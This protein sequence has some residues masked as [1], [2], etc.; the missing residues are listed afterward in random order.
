MFADPRLPL[1]SSVFPLRLP[2]LFPTPSPHF[3]PSQPG[4][5][6][7]AC[8][9]HSCQPLKRHRP[10][11][12][13]I[14]LDKG[15]RR[16]A[17]PLLKCEQSTPR[18]DVPP[19]QQS[20]R[21]PA[22]VHARGLQ[23]AFHPVS[24]LLPVH[25]CPFARFLRP[26]PSKFLF[27]LPVSLV[28]PLTSGWEPHRPTGA[29]PSSDAVKAPLPAGAEGSGAGGSCGRGRPPHS[30][31]HSVPHPGWLALK[32]LDLWPAIS[33]S[34]IRDHPRSAVNNPIM[35]IINQPKIHVGVRT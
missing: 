27:L 7:L 22:R 23:G 12:F 25:G 11:C 33:S 13:R 14:C 30:H 9:T 34:V 8:S 28:A 29:P 16:S 31:S 26:S 18:A 6:G 21:F 19:Q 4:S 5:R 24:P 10:L 3:P 15:Q 1:A 20:T 2:P 32:G 35:I 17:S